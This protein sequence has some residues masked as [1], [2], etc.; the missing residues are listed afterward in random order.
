VFWGTTLTI[1]GIVSEIV[2]FVTVAGH[3]AFLA[4]LVAGG[5]VAL[6]FPRSIGLHIAAVGWGIGSVV[7]HWPCPL[8]ELERWARSRAGM[9]PLPLEGFNEH[10]LTGV[11]YPASAVGAVQVLVFTLVMLSWV[12]VAAR[13]THR[14]SERVA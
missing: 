6:R 7:L 1:R 8:T 10:Y 4:Y 2:V 14:P 13:R 3:F 12:L 11:L 9:A 5:F